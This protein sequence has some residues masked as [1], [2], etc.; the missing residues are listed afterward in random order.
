M[1]WRAPVLTLRGAACA[2]RS[3]SFSSSKLGRSPPVFTAEAQRGHRG[4]GAE[5]SSDLRSQISNLR[6][7]FLRDLCVSVVNLC[8][9]YIQPG[10]LAHLNGGLQLET[11]FFRCRHRFGTGADYDCNCMAINEQKETS[12]V[13]TRGARQNGN[14]RRQT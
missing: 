7:A 11:L 6:S 9:W 2:I 12:L 3:R 5:P 4:D 1:T 13:P 8:P 10:G 14:G